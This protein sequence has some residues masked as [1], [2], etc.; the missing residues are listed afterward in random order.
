MRM[1]SRNVYSNNHGARG[2]DVELVTE[3]FID[4][5]GHGPY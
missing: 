4:Q 5:V 2:P 3:S 1:L